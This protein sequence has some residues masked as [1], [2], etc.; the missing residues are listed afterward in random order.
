VIAVVVF[1]FDVMMMM[2]MMMC[3]LSLLVQKLDVASVNFKACLRRKKKNFWYM[4]LQFF[5]DT[6]DLKIIF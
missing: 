3:P 1:T 5:I 6:K 2:M 4:F